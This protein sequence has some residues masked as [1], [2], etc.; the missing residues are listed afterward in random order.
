VEMLSDKKATVRDAIATNR[1]SRNVVYF[2]RVSE[3]EPCTV[4]G[5]LVAPP[6]AGLLESPDGVSHGA[7]MVEFM[8]LPSPRA[9]KVLPS[10][11]MVME[12]PPESWCTAKTRTS[13]GETELV[14]GTTM[15]SKSMIFSPTATMYRR[16]A[17]L[18]YIRAN[19]CPGPPDP[20]PPPRKPYYNCD[21]C[22]IPPHTTAIVVSEILGAAAPRGRPQEGP[23]RFLSLRHARVP[24]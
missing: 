14:P 3:D 22:P 9:W 6:G 10:T 8:K 4:Q 23:E 15:C 5:F 2:Y 13:N 18:D 17:A 21:N 20:P 11:N 12:L 19:F 16:I 1:G 24:N 7:K